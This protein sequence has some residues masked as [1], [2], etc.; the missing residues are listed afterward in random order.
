MQRQWLSPWLIDGAHRGSYGLQCIVDRH[1][2]LCIGS[3]SQVFREPAERSGNSVLDVRP[4]LPLDDLGEASQV[5]RN[6][7]LVSKDPSAMIAAP[8]RIQDRSEIYRDR[9]NGRFDRSRAKHLWSEGLDND[10]SGVQ[11]VVKSISLDEQVQDFEQI[12][13]DL[14]SHPRRQTVLVRIIQHLFES[15]P[16]DVCQDSY[17]AAN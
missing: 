9:A 2:A 7:V 3:R 14:S 16:H 8:V 1:D 10:V 11:I 5:T 12:R 17:V 6:L 15:R 13:C 4:A